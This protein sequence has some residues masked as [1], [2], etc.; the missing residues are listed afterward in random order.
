MFQKKKKKK[1]KMKV[2]TFLRL[3]REKSVKSKC[4]LRINTKVYHCTI[5]TKRIMFSLFID[6][7]SIEIKFEAEI[8]FKMAAIVNAVG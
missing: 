7:E 3:S 6:G 2:I 5:C 1:K 8:K 4:Y